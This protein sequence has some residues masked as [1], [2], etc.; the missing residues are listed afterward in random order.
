[1]LMIMNIRIF[2][3]CHPQF[4]YPKLSCFL[5]YYESAQ[6]QSLY[7][8]WLVSNTVWYVIGSSTPINGSGPVW[9]LFWSGLDQSVNRSDQNSNRIASMIHEGDQVVFPNLFFFLN[10]VRTFFL[11]LE[12]GLYL[13]GCILPGTNRS[14]Q[15]RLINLRGQIGWCSK[16]T[17]DQKIL[18]GSG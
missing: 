10:F 7:W 15:T 8:T 2:L 13:M 16:Q 1:M 6:F 14:G 4:I 17:G 3:L 18:N 9:I 5:T 11:W 12:K